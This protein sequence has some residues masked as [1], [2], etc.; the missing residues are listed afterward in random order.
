MKTI[1]SFA[2]AAGL[3]ITLSTAANAAATLVGTTTNPTGIDGLVVDGTTYNVTFST[4]TLNTFT[5]GSTVSTDARS[6]LADALNALNVTSL[7]GASPTI[8]YELDIDNSL[9]PFFDVAVC[10]N[11]CN[12]GDW[13]SG[14]FTANLNLGY[15][16]Y[17]DGGDHA[18]YVEAADFTP[19]GVPEPAIWTVML[20]GF[21][22]IGAM[23]RGR[24]Q[25]TSVGAV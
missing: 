23:M 19:V 1:A 15:A 9:T 10:F 6:A 5:F 17:P 20:L 22:G 12:A 18:Y 7:G 25:L 8:G 4:T 16:F 13:L 14:F 11:T 24:K 21:A 2:L 3:A